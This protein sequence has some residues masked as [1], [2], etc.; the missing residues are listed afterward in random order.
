MNYLLAIKWVERG[1]VNVE[2]FGIGNAV[3]VKGTS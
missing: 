3:G 1:N 2:H